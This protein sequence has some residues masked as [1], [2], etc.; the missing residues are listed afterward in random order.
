MANHGHAGPRIGVTLGEESGVGPEV[1]VEAL[2]A[3]LGEDVGVSVCVGPGLGD[4]ARRRLLA[5]WPNGR[6]RLV[7]EAGAAQAIQP[8]PGKPADGSNFRAF[9][10][11][12][13]LIELARGGQVQAIVTGP[14][15]K[16]I[17]DG[18]APRPPGQTEHVASRMGAQRFAMMLAGPSLRVVP[19]TT[20]VA[21]RDV[22]GL[23]RSEAIIGCAAAAAADLRAHFGIAA[24]RV[25]VCG[26]NP[27][28]GENGLLGDEEA[29]IIA[30]AVAGLRHL[31]IDAEGPLS[32]DSAFSDGLDGVYDVIVCMYHDQALGPL[33]T[34]H[35]RTAINFTCGLPV[36]RMSPD[37]GTA[38]AIA[39]TGAADATSATLAVQRAAWIAQAR[40]TAET[41]QRGGGAE[42]IN[43]C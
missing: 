39:G 38:M 28:A 4:W 7:E 41:A 5:R 26:L 14:V 29:R 36:P 3:A 12:E 37:H 25:G 19:V 42:E 15:T 22:A 6:W 23:L 18:V 9:R 2:G 20:H 1:M 27:H 34:V 43:A 13:L 24:P 32:A 8:T 11:L 35:R 16:A 31:G 33:K 21:L 17:F 40:W 30:P 10:A